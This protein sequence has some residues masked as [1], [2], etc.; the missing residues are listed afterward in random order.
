MTDLEANIVRADFDS[1]RDVGPES[2]VVQGKLSLE[3]L[4]S[5]LL[6]FRVQQEGYR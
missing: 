3:Q 4:K 5:V 2:I 6:V 1:P